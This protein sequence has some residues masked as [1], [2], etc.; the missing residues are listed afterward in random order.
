MTTM[1]PR[2]LWST[3][4]GWGIVANLIP[5]ELL[6]ARRARALRKLV[7]AGLCL[8]VLLAVA[9]GGYAKLRSHEAA[10]S[11]AAEQS[12]TSQLVVQQN[13]YSTV[14]RIQ[15]DVAQVRVQL[16]TLMGMDVDA[17]GLIVSLLSQL[18]PGASVTQ[19]A[20]TIAAPTP[21]SANNAGASV[22]DTSG[23]PHIGT[24]TMSGEARNVSDVA[25]LVT[26]LSQV[27]GLVDPYPTTNTVNDSGTQFT[28][29][30]AI[31][32]SLLSH[33]YDASSTTPLGSATGGK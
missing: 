1:Q 20:L 14:T 33:R 2:E 9:G 25:L 32:S 5:P 27:K 13:R 19:L 30:L 16:A 21:T 11:L 26:R 22:L 12:R 17:S 24:I 29:Q 15:G 31:N 6:Q 3:M 7:T 28:I 8:L 23:Q 4:P 10:Q 18:P